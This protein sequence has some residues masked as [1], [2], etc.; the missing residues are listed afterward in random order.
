MIGSGANVVFNGAVESYTFTTFR[1][2]GFHLHEIKVVGPIDLRVRIPLY[3]ETLRHSLPPHYFC[4]IDN[5]AG[6]ENTVTFEDIRLLDNIL[7]EGGIEFYYGAIISK[8][9]GYPNIIKLAEE[10]LYTVGIKNELLQVED[11]PSAEAFI[12]QKIAEVAALRDRKA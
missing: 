5:S 6:H 10:N 4:I 9:Q 8:D 3:H 12:N 7:L 11:R 1:V 2:K